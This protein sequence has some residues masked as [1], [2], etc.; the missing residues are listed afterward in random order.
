MRDNGQH[1]LLEHAVFKHMWR[2]Y[3][4][5][6]KLEFTTFMDVFP[7]RLNSTK[8]ILPEDEVVGI[9]SEL[10]LPDKQVA[11]KVGASLPRIMMKKTR[12]AIATKEQ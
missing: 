6:I 2:Q 1:N 11:F 4:L 8:L 9:A 10:A 3:G 12:G 5:P 7:S